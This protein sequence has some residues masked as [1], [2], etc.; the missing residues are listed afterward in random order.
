MKTSDFS[1]ELPQ[2]LIAQYPPEVRGTSR[3]MVLDREKGIFSDRH[4]GDITDYFGENDVLVVNNTKVRKARIYGTSRT[5]GRVEFF[6][7]RPMADG[8]WEVICKKS[9]KQT[10][11]KEYDFPEGVTAVITGEKEDSK[12]LRFSQPIDD[13]YLDLHA[14]VPL[15]PYIKRTD[16]EMDSNRY[17]TI[18]ARNTGSV[19]APT[20]GL[21]FTDEILKKLRAKGTEILEVTLHVG[22]GTFF[23]VRSENIEDHKMHTEEYL[24]PE[25]VAEKLNRAKKEGKR[26]TAVGTTSMR[27]LESACRNGIIPAGSSSTSIFIYPG[28]S[29]RFVDRLFTNFHTPESTLLMLVSA[30]AGE[31]LIKDAYMHAVKEKYRF[32][33]YGDCMIIL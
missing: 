8:S 21:H 22:A 27:T 26:I 15:P 17:Q 11:G 28:Y 16:E 3:M 30:F 5:G 1:F 6:L 31:K 10:V 2:E 24:I 13:A 20:A 23:P 12:I 25:D 18:Y 32:F 29:F 19:A 9:R 7:L 14:H 33:S 4:I